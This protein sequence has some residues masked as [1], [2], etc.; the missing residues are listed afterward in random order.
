V[1]QFVKTFFS[2]ISGI[3]EKIYR[4]AKITLSLFVNDAMQSFSFRQPKRKKS[5]GAR[6]GLEVGSATRSA[7]ADSIISEESRE[8]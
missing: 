7:F 2:S 1:I 6:S 8:L 3:S 5:L 4:I